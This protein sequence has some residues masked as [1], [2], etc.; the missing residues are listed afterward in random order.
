MTLPEQ[1]DRAVAQTRE[2]LVR[3]SS[4]YAEGGI[5]GIRGEVRAEASRLLRHYPY[6]WLSEAGDC[7]DADNAAKQDILADYREWQ[8]GLPLRIGTHSDRCHMRHE[9]CMIH[10]LAREVERLRN[11]TAKPD[12]STLTD[13]ERE[14]VAYF[15]QWGTWTAAAAHA[16]TLRGLLDRLK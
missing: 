16:A 6:A 4:P 11:R 5:K 3:L 9:R 15:A 2:F 14:A 13:D 12:S 7:P 8:E 10:R 1:S